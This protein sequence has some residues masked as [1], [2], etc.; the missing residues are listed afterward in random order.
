[1]RP[2]TDDEVTRI[3]SGFTSKRDCALFFLGVRTGFRITELLSLKVGDVVQGGKI[4][5]SVGVARRNMKG[6]IKGRTVPLH[7]EARVALANWV[8]E[9]GAAG[10]TATSPLFRSRK[11][12]SITRTQ[13]WKVLTAAYSRAGVF[14]RLGT[15]GLRN[16]A[17][18]RTMPS[19]A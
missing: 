13:A 16:Y 18:T 17:D 3:A 8:T 4:T 14:G 19:S 15:H 11:G 1:M 5:H 6:K 12:G 10:A 9:L 7:E 2:L